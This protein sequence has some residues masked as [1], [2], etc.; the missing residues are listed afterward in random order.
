MATCAR[1]MLASHGD[2]RAEMRDLKAEM[3]KWMTATII[4]LLV[5]FGS[6]LVAVFTVLRQS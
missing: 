3:H 4:S 5:G 2:I 1:E 6:M